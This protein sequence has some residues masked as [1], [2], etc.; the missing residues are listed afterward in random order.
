VLTTALGGALLGAISAWA[1]PTRLVLSSP[2]FH[3]GGTIPARCTC[4]G[5]NVS[6]P[7]RWSSPP[8][9]ARSLAILM[10]DPDAPGATFT[11]WIGWN[12]PLKARALRAGQR[13]P[14]EGRNDAGRIGYTGP[15]P[16]SG[17]H[18]YV[19]RLYAL[20]APLELAR[21]ASRKQFLAALRRKTLAIAR[22]VGRYSR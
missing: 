5:A 3:A 14:R 8:K 22:V 13:A 7:L 9:A 16:P 18:R 2:A 21:G 19:F 4:D 15:C 10:D 20:K 6:P 12:I 1:V 17:T 11:H